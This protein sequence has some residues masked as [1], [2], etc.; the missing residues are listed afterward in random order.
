MV[1]PNGYETNR[2]LPARVRKELDANAQD[3]YRVAYNNALAAGK[4]TPAATKAAW[5][6]VAR[7]WRLEITSG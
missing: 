7:G 2:E 5:D 4:A 3:V 1:K 6:A